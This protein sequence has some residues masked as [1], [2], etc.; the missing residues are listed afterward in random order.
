MRSTGAPSA[1][2]AL[3]QLPHRGADFLEV[4]AGWG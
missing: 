4:S 2:A 1:S 3:R